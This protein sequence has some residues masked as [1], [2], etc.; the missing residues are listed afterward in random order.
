VVWL[1][2]KQSGL[3]MGGNLKCLE[4]AIFQIYTS[5][6]TSSDEMFDSYVEY[7]MY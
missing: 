1:K 3:G 7:C 6:V 5:Q 4:T 2:D